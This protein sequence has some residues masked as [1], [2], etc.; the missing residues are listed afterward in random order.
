[1]LR[2]WSL[3]A[4]ACGAI[5]L[6]IAGSVSINAQPA[7]PLVR[8]QTT[9]PRTQLDPKAMDILKAVGDRLRTT[10]TL[11]FAAADRVEWQSREGTPLSASKTFDVTL[12]RPNKLRV[13]VSTDGSRSAYFYCNGSTMMTYSG[14]AKSVVIAKAPATITDCLNDANKA[15][16]IS[17]PFPVLIVADPFGTLSR[18]LKRADYVGRSQLADG[19][20][21][22]S[23]AYSSDNVSVQMMV[24]TED[25][26]PRVIHVTSMDPNRPRHDLVLSKWRIDA[27]ISADAFTSLSITSDASAGQ[28][29]AVGTSGVQ[30]AARAR[31]LAIHTLAPKYWG[32]GS[33]GGVGAYTNYYGNYYGGQAPMPYPGAAYYSSPDGYGYY[34]PSYSSGYY[35]SATASYAAEP[36]YDCDTGWTTEGAPIPGAPVGSDVEPGTANFDIA[37]T[38]GWYNA[39]PPS[40]Y[41]FMAPTN[42]PSQPTYVPGQV[43]TRLPVGCA[44]PYPRGAAFYLCGNTWFSGVLGPDG[45]LY[46]RVITVPGYGY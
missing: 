39:S 10:R 19:T 31:S 27:P 37:L 11:S 6:V 20:T 3:R 29:G 30:A 8:K 45:R 40:D 28:S 7:A 13:S 15:S 1:M 33:I 4:G 46:F 36:C 34:P 24:G 18:G 32:T 42:T 21:T 22:D 43:V 16:S 9:S 26:L 2:E 25:Q 35:P 5:A 41:D 23:V 38:S 17:F 44:A 14:A 12:Q